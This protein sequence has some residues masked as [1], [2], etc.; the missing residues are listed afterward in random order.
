MWGEVVSWSICFSQ[1]LLHVWTRRANH[2][3]RFSH[4][5]QNDI[6]VQ[7]ISFAPA[8]SGENIC[9]LIF[10]G[11]TDWARWWNLDWPGYTMA[12]VH[13]YGN[14]SLSEAFHDSRGVYYQLEAQ[15]DACWS[16]DSSK[17]SSEC[18]MA[19]GALPMRNAIKRWSDENFCITAV[20]LTPNPQW[21]G[22]NIRCDRGRTEKSP[23]SPSHHDIHSQPLQKHLFLPL[24]VVL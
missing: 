7:K 12:D 20:S 17:D 18:S 3:S 11:L 2:G 5:L 19:V 24:L 6:L 16:A 15:R 1:I 9:S 22:H 4:M 8:T 23:T 13:V 10:H 21:I 14:N